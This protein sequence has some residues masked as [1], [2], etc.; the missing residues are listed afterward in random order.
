MAKLI[1]LSPSNHGAGANKCLKKGCYEDKHTRPIAN[2]AAKYL[3]YSGFKVIVASK[4]KTMAK[5]CAEADK[6]NAALYVPIHTNASGTASARYL[7]FMCIAKTGEY[8]KLFNAIAPEFEKIYP[9]KKEAVFAVRKDLYEINAPKAKTF[10][11]ELGFHTN[12][13]DCNDFIHNADALGKA[14]AKGIC[15]YYGVPFKSVK[16]KDVNFKVKVKVNT[17]NVRSGPGTKYAVKSKIKDKGIYTIVEQKGS[18]GK[19]KSGK[20]WICISSFYCKKA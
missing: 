8:K 17:L 6:N 14:L 10:Y 11:C 16:S 15:K 9:G 20:G 1:Y 4:S 2:A 12:K 3:K 19:L 5:R 18:W 13:T 7:M